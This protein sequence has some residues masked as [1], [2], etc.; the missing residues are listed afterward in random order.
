M[1][2]RH[3]A[4]LKQLVIDLQRCDAEW[5]SRVWS[6][7]AHGKTDDEAVIGA[8]GELYDLYAVANPSASTAINS[9]LTMTMQQA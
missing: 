8:F 3:R 6:H 1:P 9:T 5:E 2:E 7:I 4:C